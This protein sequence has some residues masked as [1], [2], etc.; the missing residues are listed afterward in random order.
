[1]FHDRRLGSGPQQVN[2]PLAGGP[3]RQT[4]VSGPGVTVA[5]G[6]WGRPAGNSAA[7]LAGRVSAP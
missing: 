1:M 6:H 5:A 7:P 4:A 3:R 2:A